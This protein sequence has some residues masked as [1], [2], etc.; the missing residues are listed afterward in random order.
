MKTFYNLL[1]IIVFSITTFAQT[2]IVRGIVLD[3]NR[4]PITNVEVFTANSLGTT[5]DKNGVYSLEIPANSLVTL[6]FTSI[7]L[8]KVQLN[9][10]L[11]PNQD[12]EFNPVL[13]IDAE[14]LGTVI[15]RSANKATIEGLVSVDPKTIRSLPSASAG[16]EALLKTL[17][18]VSNNNELSTQYNVR[19]GNFDENLVYVNEIEVYRPFLIRSGQ[20]EGLSFVN[21][22]LVKNVEFSAGGFQAKY[23]DKLSSVL[24]V[25]YKQPKKYGANAE[26]SFLGGSLSLGGLSK[27]AKTSA[28]VGA[29]YRD[30]SFLVD[31][32]DTESNFR[33]SFVDVQAYITHAFSSKFELSFLGNIATNLYEFE[34]TT[35]QTNFGTIDSPRALNVVFNGQE[36]DSYRTFFGALKAAYKPTK[37]LSLRFFSSLYQT[38]EQEYFDIISSYLVGRVSNA[39]GSD[40]FGEIDFIDGVG[41]QIAHARNDLDALIFNLQHKGT[42]TH[43]TNQFD[44]GVRYSREDIRDRVREFEFVDNSGNFVSPNL[45]EINEPSPLDPFDNRTDQRIIPFNN[46]RA[47]NKVVINRFSGFGQ[48]SKQ[49]FINDHKIWINAGVRAQLWNVIGT[50]NNQSLN[51][52]NQITISPRGQFAIQPAWKKDMLFRLSTGLYHQPPF[53]R[54]LRN[55][56]GEVIPDVEAQQSFHI[57]LSNDYSFKMWDRPFKLTSEIYYKNLT[58]VNTYTVEN[59]R[60]RYRANNNA[61]A[62]AQ[63]LDFRINGEFVP[64]TESWFSLGYLKTEENQDNRGFIARPTDQRLKVGVLFQDYVKKIPNLKAYINL[65]YQ[66]GLPGGSPTGADPYEFQQRLRDYRRADIGTFYELVSA[67][68]KAKTLRFLNNFKS[69]EIGFEIFNIFDFRN[70]AT[71]TFVRDANSG[72]QFSIPNFLTPRLLNVKL[73]MEL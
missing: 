51:S 3:E 38:Q 7:G 64:G 30:N 20:Q 69:F 35:R 66:T 44:W 48:W 63:G 72:N 12:F 73:R 36:Q 68:K 70:A 56:S 46:V 53:Y 34:P 50:G 19:G 60:V 37:N 67:N 8:K 25:T 28:I 65:V 55:L 4:M 15:V 62:F 6:T 16:V 45:P 41:S 31:A 52:E 26:L 49:T 47:T 10:T 54:E 39:I 27:N 13:K 22:D 1:F 59:V 17:P 18:G 42:F 43:T 24:D 58:N 14:Q 29:R 32:R 23:G 5:S 40:S 9:I 61:T 57:S 71:N 21:T 2:A 33:Q 11:K